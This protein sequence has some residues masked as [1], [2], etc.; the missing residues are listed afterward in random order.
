MDLSIYCNIIIPYVYSI[1]GE[2]RE[3]E[4]GV[5]GGDAWGEKGEGGGG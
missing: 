2:E 3:G 4:N 5:G 1:L